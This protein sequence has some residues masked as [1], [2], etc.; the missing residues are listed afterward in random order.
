MEQSI[1]ENVMQCINTRAMCGKEMSSDDYMAINELVQQ[2]GAPKVLEVVPLNNFSRT[3]MGMVMRVKNE[4][5]GKVAIATGMSIRSLYLLAPQR[6]AHGTIPLNV[7]NDIETALGVEQSGAINRE[8]IARKFPESTFPTKNSY[9]VHEF[10]ARVAGTAGVVNNEEFVK[11]NPDKPNPVWSPCLGRDGVIATV[12]YTDKYTQQTHWGVLVETNASH[13]S[14]E[15]SRMPAYENMSF[16]EATNSPGMNTLRRMAAMNNDALAYR[17]L[18]ALELSKHMGALNEDYQPATVTVNTGA[19]KF[20][21]PT[22][23]T[24]VSNA[25]QVAFDEVGMGNAD[26]GLLFMNAVDIRSSPRGVI[27]DKGAPQGYELMFSRSLEQHHTNTDEELEKMQKLHTWTNS[28]YNAFPTG[29]PHTSNAE[30]ARFSLSETN[31]TLQQR[32]ISEHHRFANK[33]AWSNDGIKFNRNLRYPS[34]HDEQNEVAVQELLGWNHR[35]GSLTAT[36]GMSF[37]SRDTGENVEMRDVVLHGPNIPSHFQY[38]AGVDKTNELPFFVIPISSNILPSITQHYHKFKDYL[39]TEE[40]TPTLA[41]V[42]G[43]QKGD[44]MYVPSATLISLFNM[45]NAE[46]DAEKQGL[47]DPVRMALDL[48]ETFEQ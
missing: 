16:S 12:R 15:L 32:L 24:I 28:M 38:E 20:L 3:N 1:P 7:K 36:T 11:Q 6:D 8:Y 40:G 37:I 25:R 33:L 44:L 9:P 43:S 17:A 26:D 19:E 34:K 21:V 5:T 18:S 47:R 46:S 48:S 27:F 35:W 10:L 29:V 30:L 2:I 31:T 41:Q 14:N 22:F 13:F 42:L 45:M 23:S 4:G 39:T